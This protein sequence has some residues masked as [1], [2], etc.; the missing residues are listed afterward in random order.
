MGM[1]S[2]L[3]GGSGAVGALG[4]AAQ[5]LSQVF[6]PNATEGQR[7][8]HEGRAAALE[9]LTA[10]FALE[11]RGMFDRFIDGLN[12]LPR[13]MLAMGTLGLFVYAMAEPIGFGVRMQGLNHVPEPLWWLLGAI[14]GF[15]FGVRELHYLRPSAPTVTMRAEPV[16]SAWHADDEETAAAAAGETNAALR[17]WQGK[18]K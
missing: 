18:A 12:R 10:E 11:R 2:G 1:M 3:I 6:V 9:Q 13:P 17:D 16:N 7:L 8:D 4:R 5:E 14:V 15:Y